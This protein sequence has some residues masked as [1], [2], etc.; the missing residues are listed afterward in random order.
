MGISLIII[1]A[2]GTAL[3]LTIDYSVSTPARLT[4]F[5]NEIQYRRTLEGLFTGAFLTTD[6]E[7]RMSFF[8]A[9][10]SGTQVGDADTVTWVTMS[11]NPEGGFL[12][13]DSEDFEQLHEQ[14]GPQGGNSEVS[15][16]LSPVGD[17]GDRSGLFLRIQ[18]PA[19]GDSTQG[20][21]ETLLVDGITSATYEFWDGTQWITTWDT[22]NGGSRRLPAAV[23]IT[24]E[25]EEGT[26]EYL[27]FR[28]PLSDVT[29]ENPITQEGGGDGGT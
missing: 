10:N 25:R 15:I 29:A 21:T 18:T 22:I 23:R 19:D 3:K 16:S 27:V 11:K 28:L 12:T 7:D 20:G 13:S 6:E 26:P 14:Y 8:V 24:L 2:I 17:A 1:G 4:A 5:Q 9:S